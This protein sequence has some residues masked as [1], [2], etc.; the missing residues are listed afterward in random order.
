MINNKLYEMGHFNKEGGNGKNT[1]AKEEG[2]GHLPENIS[3]Y[4]VRHWVLIK[5]MI[6]KL[7]NSDNQAPGNK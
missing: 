6:L 2:S 1:D 3:L 4:Y 7:K 5:K